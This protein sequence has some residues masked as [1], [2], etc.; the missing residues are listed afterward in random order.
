MAFG[1]RLALLMG[2][3]VLSVVG[4][5]ALNKYLWSKDSFHFIILLTFT[6]YFFSSLGTRV[7]LYLGVFTYK[8]VPFGYTVRLALGALCSV[9]FMNLNLTSNS[10]GFYQLSKLT[11]IPVTLLIERCWHGKV[12]PRLVK[13]SLVPLLFGACLATV[14]DVSVN[15]T[16]TVYAACGILAT[17]YSQIISS[18]YYGE[19]ECN[20][21]QLLYHV[22]PLVSFG[23]IL[24]VPVFDDMEG[25]AKYDWPL[26]A[27]LRVS[28]SCV[29]ALSVQ[30]T[31]FFVL[32][33]TC[34][35]TYQ[36][37]GHLKTMFIL[38]LGF[39]I[40]GNPIDG[41]NI[42]GIVIALV[43]VIMYTE[44]KRRGGGKVVPPSPSKSREEQRLKTLS[45]V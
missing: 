6:H 28:A 14:Y 19:L 9:G 39:T 37:L 2:L 32:G 27:R 26:A 7:L 25:L 15:F 18:R 29:M 21:L 38:M 43:G 36:V 10:V 23:M 8:P 41:R 44:V 20:A 22:A 1:A 16:G 40:F 5:V 45:A 35:L 17:V 11:C 33:K 34:P 30:M 3:N 31:N 42:L 24:L 12:A 4:V 13:L